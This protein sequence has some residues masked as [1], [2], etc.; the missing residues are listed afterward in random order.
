MTE[1]KRCAWAESSEKM[2]IY[3]DTVWGVAE[4][5]E[6]R[7]FKKMILDGFQAGLS[8]STVLNKMEHISE[9]FDDFDPEIVARYDAAKIESLLADPGIIRNRSKVESAVHNAQVYLR[10]QERGQSFSDYLW[11]FC[12]HQVIVNHWE[13]DED[14][15]ATTALSDEISKALRGEGFKYVGS[16]IVYAFMQAVGMVDDH[17]LSCHCRQN[18]QLIE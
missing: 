8:W 15:P 3:H 2:R 10:I 6:Q 14:V 12:D 11:D 1:L 16:T 13:R 18:R 17:I 5:D 4:Y 7:L 9:V